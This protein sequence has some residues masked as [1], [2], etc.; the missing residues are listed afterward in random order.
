MH[1]DGEEGL[2][3]SLDRLPH[4]NKGL[5]AVVPSSVCGIDAS[6]VVLEGRAVEHLVGGIRSSS[7]GLDE[8]DNVRS[9]QEC[10][11]NVATRLATV[12]V[13]HG[14]DL[15]PGVLNT[16]GC[17]NTIGKGRQCLVGSNN[18]I[19][20]G[21]RVVLNLLQ[22]DQVGNAQLADDLLNNKRQ[23]SRLGVK[24]LSVVIRHRDALA[25]AFAGKANSRVLG[26]GALLRLGGG[27]RKNTIE[28][29]GIGDNTSDFSH[30][31]A[32]LGVVGILGTIQGRANG[33]GLGVGIYMVSQFC[34]HLHG[35][36]L[37]YHGRAWSNHHDG[38]SQRPSSHP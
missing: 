1:V 8:L 23:V 32:E 6:R 34:I 25:R 11:A 18:A 7:V 29:K 26:V 27:Q 12:L 36:H 3:G 37:T 13:V 28:A 10:C 22:E 9:V 14:I 4:G 19:V 5:A 33:D 21:A 15:S 20:G 31:V 24:I 2:L 30:V 38:S 17:L 35:R 16:A